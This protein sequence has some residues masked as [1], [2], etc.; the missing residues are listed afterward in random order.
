MRRVFGSSYFTTL[1]LAAKGLA[2]HAGFKPGRRSYDLG[3]RVAR[4]P[5]QRM[6]R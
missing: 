4:T 1:R 6:N 3:L 5:V 2:L